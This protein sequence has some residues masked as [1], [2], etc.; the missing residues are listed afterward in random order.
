MTVTLMSSK[1]PSEQQVQN[2]ATIKFEKALQSLEQASVSL[3]EMDSLIESQQSIPGEEENPEST[4]GTYLDKDDP[5][6]PIDM[7]EGKRMLY[8]FSVRDDLRTTAV[9]CPC[10]NPGALKQYKKRKRKQNSRT[11]GSGRKIKTDRGR[12]SKKK[13]V[14]QAYHRNLIESLAD[15]PEKRQKEV[16][17]MARDHAIGNLPT[18]LTDKIIPMTVEKIEEM[19]SEK[20]FLISAYNEYLTDEQKDQL[21][22]E[23]R[24]ETDK[25]QKST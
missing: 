4:R 5:S 2:A 23:A 10:A 22:R 9:Q 24:Q 11:G 14:D 15:E 16:L 25:P 13:Q 3:T 12:R 8:L 18:R 6:C 21:R 19:G 1:P 7:C 17:G 20:S